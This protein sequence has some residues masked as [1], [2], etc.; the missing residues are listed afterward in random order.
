MNAHA[1]FPAVKPPLSKV[2]KDM[3]NLAKTLRRHAHAYKR[4]A[5][6][7]EASGN[8]KL[9]RECRA[10]STEAWRKAR[11]YCFHAGLNRLSQ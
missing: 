3:L 5:L 9:Y 1:R 4:E 10:A 11:W 8:L 2:G 6:S 7:Y